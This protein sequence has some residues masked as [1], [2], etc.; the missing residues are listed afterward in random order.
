MIVDL[1]VSKNGMRDKSSAD[2]GRTVAKLA[3]RLNTRGV[4]LSRHPLNLNKGRGENMDWHR[5][6]IHSI[7]SATADFSYACFLV[8]LAYST[9]F[10][11]VRKDEELLKTACKD[12]I[13]NKSEIWVLEISG[14]QN[15]KELMLERNRATK[16]IQMNH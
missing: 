8:P 2:A 14:H 10:N 1:G 15:A 6:L 4:F 12:N 13:H 9:Y 7:S 3:R 5:R 16:T 11:K